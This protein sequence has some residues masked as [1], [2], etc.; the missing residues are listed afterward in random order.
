MFVPTL[1]GLDLAALSVATSMHECFR[2]KSHA[3]GRYRCGI[4]YYSSIMKTYT[5]PN[6]LEPHVACEVLV[7]FAKKQNK[8]CLLVPTSD[9]YL[10][11][12]VRLRGELA[13]Y[14]RLVLPEKKLY[15]QI[16]DKESFYSLLDS[17][18]IKHPKT[19]P[20]LIGAK[21]EWDEF[22]CVLKPSSSVEAQKRAFASQKKVYIIKNREELSRTLDELRLYQSG[23]RYLLQPYI[24]AEKSYVLSVF[25]QERFGT[26]RAALAEVVVEEHGASSRGNYSALLVRDLNE[27]SRKLIAFCDSIGYEGIANFDIISREGTDYVLEMNP[28]MG[29][30][31]DYLRGAGHSVADFLFKSQNRSIPYPEGF[32][33]VPIYWRC[34]RDKEVLALADESLCGEIRRKLKMNFSFSPFS[35]GRTVWHPLQSLYRMVHLARRGRAARAKQG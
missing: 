31:S 15:R 27:I 5:E 28:R 11:L 10:D 23:M 12:A 9:W 22:P 34:I 35:Y 6:L 33:S 24:D 20:F 17:Y 4:S 14:Y 21:P 26:R 1:L 25:C 18:G 3:F 30:S 13:P 29:R 32:A 2:I 19:Y 7:D 16:S 8:P